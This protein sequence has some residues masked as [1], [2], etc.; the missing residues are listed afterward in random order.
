MNHKRKPSNVASTVNSFWNYGLQASWYF[1]FFFNSRH[2]KLN[3]HCEFAGSRLVHLKVSAYRITKKKRLIKRMEPSKLWLMID[4]IN[5]FCIILTE[6][7]CR[8]C[9]LFFQ[10][11]VCLF[12]CFSFCSSFVRDLFPETVYGVGQGG[13]KT[14]TGSAK[15]KVSKQNQSRPIY[16]PLF[17]SCRSIS[18]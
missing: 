13:H 8:K 2:L 4:F 5:A 6:M 7:E 16:K 3:L 17:F 12:V 1:N 15:I 9:T 11:F 18:F 10:S 14:N